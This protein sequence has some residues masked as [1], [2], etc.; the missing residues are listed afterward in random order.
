MQNLRFAGQ[1]YDSETDL[2]YNYHR[3][4]DPKLGRYLRAD[5]LGLDA[6]V[7]LFAYVHGNPINSIDPDGQFAWVLPALCAG[8]GCEAAAGAIAG[9]GLG[10]LIAVIWDGANGDDD[11]CGPIIRKINKVMKELN[12]RYLHQC[13]NKKNQ[14]ESHVP[15]FE[16]KKRQLAKLVAQAEAKGC[17]VPPKAYV[18]LNTECPSPGTPFS[19][20]PGY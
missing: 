6:G 3:Y 17:A 20:T 19:T 11:C 12:K 18:W 16:G 13:K 5:P 14:W 4:Y 10:G 2:H 8:G 15:A 1:Y 7:N 9:I